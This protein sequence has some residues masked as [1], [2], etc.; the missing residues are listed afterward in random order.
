MIRETEALT[1]SLSSRLDTAER[2]SEMKDRFA[3]MSQDAAQ[4]HNEMENRR[5]VD[6]G[7]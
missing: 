6:N 1:G 5:S 2:I 7:D 3:E 4:R